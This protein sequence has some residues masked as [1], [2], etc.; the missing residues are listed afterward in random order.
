MSD[1]DIDVGL[2]KLHV[3]MGHAPPSEMAKLLRLGKARAR[4]IDRCM[5]FT[6]DECERIREPRI[7]RG[8][9][10]RRTRE[11]GE[12]LGMDLIEMALSDNS[13]I[14]GVNMVDEYTS[15]QVVWPINCP[16]AQVTSEDVLLAFE[17]GWSS[18]AGDPQG[19]AVDQGKHFL[20]HFAGMSRSMGI[21][22]IPIAGGAHWQAGHPEAHGRVWKLAF[23]KESSRL[24]W[25]QKD[26]NAVLRGFSGI[27]KSHN[28]RH[29]VR[30]YS[31]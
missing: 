7:S 25:G 22:L 24:G 20:G 10:L 3:N 9:K 29:Q 31:P 28:R 15:F 17:L 1:H 12:A 26:F 23:E 30:G 8:V 4:A 13:K 2:M 14:T 16:M 19:F 6:C 11:F 21:P 5:K 27:N 18:W